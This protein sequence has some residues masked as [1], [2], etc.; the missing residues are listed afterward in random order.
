MDTR[1]KNGS[2]GF[3]GNNDHRGGIS[4]QLL[5]KSADIDTRTTLSRE[6][7]VMGKVADNK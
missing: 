2:L 3:L 1:L 7:L 6:G 4:A 5:P